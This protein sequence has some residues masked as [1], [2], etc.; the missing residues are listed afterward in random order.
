MHRGNESVRSIA[1]EII[2]GQGWLA[3]NTTTNNIA[4]TDG[5]SGCW[6]MADSDD[7]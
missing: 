7:E 5:W 6:L 2:G 4:T 1:F 3:P